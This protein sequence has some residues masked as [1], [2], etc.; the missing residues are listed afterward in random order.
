[1]QEQG[2]PP[3]PF[4]SLYFVLAFAISWLIWLPS[5]FASRGL[6][7][8][9]VDPMAFVIAGAHGPLIAS[10]ALTYRTY[11]WPGVR[12]FFKSGFDVRL[13]LRWYLVVFLLPVTFSGIALWL[14]VSTGG[15]TPELPLLE[16]P[17][18]ILPALVLAFIIFGSIQEEYGWRGY[19]LPR[20]LER[21]N[22]LVASV[23]LGLLWGL[24]H[25]PLFFIDGTS[26]AFTP[27]WVFLVLS[28]AFSVLF[29]WL[30]RRTAGNLFGA[31]LLH[32]TINLST[33]IFPPI[34]LRAGGDQRAFVWMMVL[35]AAVAAV[36]VFREREK[37][38]GERVKKLKSG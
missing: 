33:S 25:L 19:A 16:Q 38:R 18:L 17:W 26:Q 13:S 37:W 28:V 27:F 20:L 8:L 29:T 23:L 2:T 34:E 15:S 12:D 21:W 11:G 22:A 7:T 6:F 32:A 9:P 24:W 36:I 5:V 3:N 30:Y 14:K 1:M 35:Y 10:M 31:L 4:P